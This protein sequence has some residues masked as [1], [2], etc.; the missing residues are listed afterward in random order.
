[1]QLD[2]RQLK[3]M[4]LPDPETLLAEF[5]A[6]INAQVDLYSQAYTALVGIHSGGVWLMNRVLENIKIG[7]ASCRERVLVAV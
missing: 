2:P 5:T 4:Q 1:M 7:R 3:P 6:K